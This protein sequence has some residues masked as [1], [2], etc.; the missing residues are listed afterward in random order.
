[1]R[2]EEDTARELIQREREVESHEEECDEEQM[3]ESPVAEGRLPSDLNQL[4]A[5]IMTS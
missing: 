5:D 1:M 3:L 2:T 4:E